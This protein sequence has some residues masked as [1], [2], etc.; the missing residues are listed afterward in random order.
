M[1]II[2][3]LKRRRCLVLFSI[4][5]TF[6]STLS[7]VGKADFLPVYGGPTYSSAAGGYLAVDVAHAL[8]PD[9]RF[10]HVNNAG[11][12]AATASKYDSAG[13]W[14]EFRAMRWSATSAATELGGNPNSMEA[15]GINNS[16]TVIGI[17]MAWTEG[18]PPFRPPGYQS[19][20][21]RWAES[22]TTATILQ[23]PYAALGAATFLYDVNDSGTA[24]GAVFKSHFNEFG[25]AV[26]QG[27]RPGRW[28]AGGTALTELGF[29][30][31]R[32]DGWTDARAYAVNA[33]GVATGTVLNWNHPAAIADQFAPSSAVRWQAGAI[34][35]TE[36]QPLA[37]TGNQF[38]T[39][40]A[41]A[42]NDAGIV[43][44]AGGVFD[45]NGA[46]V[47]SAAVRWDA[48][49]NV[50]E[51]GNIA[52]TT[53]SVIANSP[54]AIN[55]AGTAV[56]YSGPVASND[57]GP[58]LGH[59]AI[60]WDGSSAAATE[61]G[62]LGTYTDGFTVANAFAMNASGTAVGNAALWDAPSLGDYHAVYWPANDTQAI[63]LNT[64][65]DPASGWV[66][67]HALDISDTGW[68]VGV[69]QFDPD[70]ANGQP[71]YSR[72]FLIQVPSAGV[73]VPG[74]FN[75]DGAVDV[76][77]LAQWAGDFGVDGDSDADGDGDS[78]GA[79][80]LAWQRQF[81][82]APS[83]LTTADPVPEPAALW[84][85]LTGVALTTRRTHAKSSSPGQRVKTPSAPL[86]SPLEL[87]I[88]PPVA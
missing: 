77:D 30:G 28:D 47:R 66:L 46:T 37:T 78:D 18:Y 43:V 76:A 13:N 22:T 11:M 48:A 63:D 9:A 44:G 36:L 7:H 62:H 64:L 75:L 10:N 73:T 34:E 70:G 53:Y 32:S 79:D 42:I 39:T 4:T 2:R 87:N 35:A 27:L 86:R 6:A 82:G 14:L 19:R 57:G 72:H 69:G 20:P 55:N 60:R 8:Y 59:R 12:A 33:A 45:T 23:H 5:L 84:L 24:V 26:D 81:N 31:T 40:H 85:L 80:F 16:G 15:T 21:A 1:N 83:A 52:G 71:S 56:G 25:Q 41:K 17:A 50:T 88:A 38:S 65:I 3:H 67:K 58:D 49:G 51:L 29:L 54:K 61:L 74:D 68:I